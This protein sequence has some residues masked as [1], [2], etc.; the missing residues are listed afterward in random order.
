MPTIVS[1]KDRAQG[2]DVSDESS[3]GTIDAI[4]YGI[5]DLLSAKKSA[6]QLA[7]DAAATVLSVDQIIM[8]K[9]AGGPVMPKQQQP[10][11]WDQD[12]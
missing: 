11:N 1:P 6:I 5:F 8:A 10:G 12:D 9:R 4:E 2:V 7:T 3:S